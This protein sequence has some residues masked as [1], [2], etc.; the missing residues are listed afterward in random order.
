MWECVA[1]PDGAANGDGDGN[2]DEDDGDGD[3]DDEEEEDLLDVV[4]AFDDDALPLLLPPVAVPLLALVPLVPVVLLVLLLP[5]VPLFVVP[6]VGTPPPLPPLPPVPPLPPLGDGV[7]A[8]PPGQ[9]KDTFDRLC[10]RFTAGFPA[11]SSRGAKTSRLP[12]NTAALF[13]R[14]A[15]SSALRPQR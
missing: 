9:T 15:T 11:V 5:V 1:G 12:A 7:A 13:Q 10:A 14:K 8:P 3:D 2:D 4:D 6:F